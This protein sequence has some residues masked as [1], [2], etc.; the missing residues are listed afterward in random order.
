[1][2]ISNLLIYIYVKFSVFW[3]KKGQMK[4]IQAIINDLIDTG[5]SLTDPLL[6]TQVL[7]KKLNNI[8]LSKWVNNELIG[9]EDNIELPKYRYTFGQ[10]KGEYTVNGIT[11]VQNQPILASAVD[12][13]FSDFINR[14]P[15]NM[16]VESMEALIKDDKNGTLSIQLPAEVLSTISKKYREMGVY[17]FQLLT[18]SIRY[19]KTALVQA[20]SEIRS[21]LLE[22]ITELEISYGDIDLD[23]LVK[24][25]FSANNIII[26]TMENIIIDGDGN[27]LNTGKNSKIKSNI[28]IKKSDLQSL[29]QVLRNNH[30][31]EEDITEIIEIVQ[32]EK[33]NEESNQLGKRTN[34]WIKKMLGKSVDGSWQIGIGAAGKLLASA[35]GKY[36]GMV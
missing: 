13:D 32:E 7:A 35:I 31:E 12:K 22:L 16:G 9:Y 26:K 15:L 33:P 24:E 36:Y 6:K 4:L 3:N 27:F 14:L 29:E 23:E 10:L 34:D 25:K 8:S 30:L 19:S 18:A 11:I 17:N 20:L 2:M 21:K 28:K 5:K 1:M